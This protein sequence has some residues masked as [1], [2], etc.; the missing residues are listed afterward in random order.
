MGVVG[1][2]DHACIFL[3]RP[4]S[5]RRKRR[6][7]DTGT[8]H[9][10]INKMTPRGRCLGPESEGFFTT[11][12][13]CVKKE[14]PPFAADRRCVSK[15]AHDTE[16]IHVGTCPSGR[17]KKTKTRNPR[18]RLGQRRR[19]RTADQCPD[20]SRENGGEARAWVRRGGK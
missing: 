19:Q 15:A 9:G 10:H 17:T 12:V 8:R 14:D 20:A 16:M 18:G 13:L 1:V 11:C 4:R 5:M 3:I 7:V 6:R 2:P